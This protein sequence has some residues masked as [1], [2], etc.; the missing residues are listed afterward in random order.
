M[1]S[2]I[3]RRDAERCITGGNILFTALRTKG[4][5]VKQSKIRLTATKDLLMNNLKY[6]TILS[7][8]VISF[9]LWNLE[10]QMVVKGL[11]RSWGETWIGTDDDA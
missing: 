9:Y 11:Y 1:R 8:I 3:Q 5:P 10:K 7:L 2:N 6:A 4:I